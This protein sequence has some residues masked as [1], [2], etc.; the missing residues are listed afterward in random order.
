M[1]EARLAG[2]TV[3][4][5]GGFGIW[6]GEADPPLG[7][8]RAPLARSGRGKRG[9]GPGGLPNQGEHLVKWAHLSC[10]VVTLV[11]PDHREH[12]QG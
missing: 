7:V 11:R 12:G 9:R 10:A 3:S 4:G 1:V 8:L 5:A 2:T 6:Q